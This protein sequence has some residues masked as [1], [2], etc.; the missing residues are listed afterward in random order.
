MSVLE[1]WASQLPVLMT[2]QCNLP[3]GFACGGADRVEPT[4][5][6]IAEGIRRLFSMSD[7]DRTTMG[8]KGRLL[9]ESRFA[10]PTVAG[11]MQQVYHWILGGGDPPDGIEVK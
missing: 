8:H 11:R 10:W 5:A 3:E 1:A 2:D 9:V 4:P 6:S 7:D